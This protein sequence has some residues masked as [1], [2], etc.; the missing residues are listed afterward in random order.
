ML[1][2]LIDAIMRVFF[3]HNA[4]DNATDWKKSHD[5]ATKSREEIEAIIANHK[6]SK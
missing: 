5:K 6:S 4:V 1:K 3:G 2:E